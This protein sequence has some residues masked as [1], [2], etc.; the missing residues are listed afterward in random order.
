MIS[1]MQER[2]LKPVP[3]LGEQPLKSNSAQP[4]GEALD[5]RTKVLRL[6]TIDSLVHRGILM[7]L[8]MMLFS[9]AIRAVMSNKWLHVSIVPIFACCSLA[10]TR[11][12]SKD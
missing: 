11:F 7:A 1:D 3:E 9:L 6:M 10:L 5:E 2:A 4:S 12:G 8:I